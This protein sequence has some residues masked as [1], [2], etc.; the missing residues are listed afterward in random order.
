M[1]ILPIDSNF[2]PIVNELIK[3]EWA[4]PMIVT[5]G[6]TWNTSTLPGFVAI[7]DDKKFCGAVTYRISDGECE[8]T[9]LNSLTE[10]KG[11]GSSLITAVIETTKQNLCHRVWLITTN[12]NTHAIRFY[13]RFGFSI[14]AVYI[15]AIEQSRKLK[16]SIPFTGIDGIPLL[17]E[18]EFEILLNIEENMHD[19][20]RVP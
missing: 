10:N 17:H 16:P 4:G 2:R 20:R 9:S 15:N 7:D 5:K 13:Q 1:R 3:D 18:F 11:I 8:I 6:H 19:K 14:K 12:D